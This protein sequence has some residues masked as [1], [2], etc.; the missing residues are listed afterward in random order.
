M[1]TSLINHC[2]VSFTF[3]MKNFLTRA[4]ANVLVKAFE[5]DHTN[6]TPSTVLLLLLT[7]S[8]SRKIYLARFFELEIIAMATLIAVGT[9]AT[10]L[11]WKTT[12]TI[13]RNC[14]PCMTAEAVLPHQATEPY[15][16]I[17]TLDL[18]DAAIARTPYLTFI[19][20]DYGHL[21]HLRG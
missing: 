16:R 17:N 1:M 7:Y 8:S 19:V 11:S 13:G 12:S 3:T 21:T 20:A 15:N 9:V 18:G 6:S 14:A 5:T 4:S 2:F 10:P